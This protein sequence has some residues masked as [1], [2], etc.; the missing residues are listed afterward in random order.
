MRA[1]YACAVLLGCLVTLTACDNETR[2][3]EKGFRLPDGDAEAGRG[4][5]LALQ[6]HQCHTVNGEELPEIP[7]QNPPYFEL[8]GKVAKVKTYG[9][10]V[11]SIINPSHRISPKMPREMVSQDGESNMYIYN[12]HMTVQQLIDIVMYLQPKYNVVVPEYHYRI[13]PAT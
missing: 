9:D 8:G 6:C 11:T 12:S 5:F 3:S 2:M 7:G 4:T 13:Y 10:L 1:R